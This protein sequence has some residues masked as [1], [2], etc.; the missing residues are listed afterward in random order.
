MIVTYIFSLMERTE[1][2]AYQQNVSTT[3]CDG[4]Q[5]KQF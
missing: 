5:Y 3:V 4:H 1:I 2:F